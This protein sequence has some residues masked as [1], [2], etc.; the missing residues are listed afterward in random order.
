MK[1]LPIII[2]IATFFGS[3]GLF[4]DANLDIKKSFFQEQCKELKNGN[5]FV[6]Y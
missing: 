1:K 2:F 4:A 6:R 5:A 3:L